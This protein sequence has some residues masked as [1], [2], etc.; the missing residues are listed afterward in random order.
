MTSN[1]NSVL[2]QLYSALIIVDGAPSTLL[3]IVPVAAGGIVDINL[4]NPMYKK[5]K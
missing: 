2:V 1:K 3:A 4:Y 5:W